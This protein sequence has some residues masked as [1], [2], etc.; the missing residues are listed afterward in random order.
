M[1]PSVREFVTR[2]PASRSHGEKLILI[3]TLIHRFHWE[4]AAGSGGRPGACNLLEGTM[5][6]IMPFL[7]RLTYGESIPADV[8]QQRETWRRKWAQNPWSMGR[9][10]AP[11]RPA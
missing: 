10:Q 3:D 6:D 4:S 9:G 11:N 8:E 5:S 2:F 7:D 1:T